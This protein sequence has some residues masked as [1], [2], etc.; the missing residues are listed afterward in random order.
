MIVEVESVIDKDY[1]SLISQ[2][3]FITRP[4]SSYQPNPTGPNFGE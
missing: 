3:G 4:W 1:V 2:H